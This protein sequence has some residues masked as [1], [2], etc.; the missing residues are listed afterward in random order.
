MN[1]VVVREES[2]RQCGAVNVWLADGKP[3]EYCGNCRALWNLR[4]H[5]IEATHSQLPWVIKSTPPGDEIGM[6]S[7]SAIIATADGDTIVVE[8]CGGI[9]QAEQ[10]ANAEFIVKACNNHEALVTAL[11]TIIIGKYG[12]PMSPDEEP[13]LVVRAALEKAQDILANLK[14]GDK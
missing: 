3:P 10:L 14:G 5:E 2:C 7:E 6:V 12:L 4:R 13:D 8:V 1:D 11:E 9:G